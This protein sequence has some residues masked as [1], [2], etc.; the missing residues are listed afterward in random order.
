V[1]V[2]VSKVL[3]SRIRV[4]G[5]VSSIV[6]PSGWGRH[7]KRAVPVIGLSRRGKSE[8]IAVEVVLVMGA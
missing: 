4:G 1:E 8:R 6:A 7:G 3:S 5:R 2:A